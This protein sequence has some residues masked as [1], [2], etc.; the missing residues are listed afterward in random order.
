LR[1]ASDAAEAEQK[2]VDEEVARI[3]RLSKRLADVG[4]PELAA[5]QQRERV[6]VDAGAIFSAAVDRYK[7]ALRTRVQDTATRL[8]SF[9]DG[10]AVDLALLDQKDHFLGH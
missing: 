7:V 10:G 9:A 5:F 8:F 6:L 3:V 2:L 4:T 1:V